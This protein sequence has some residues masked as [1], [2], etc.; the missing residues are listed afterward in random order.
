MLLKN[1]NILRWLLLIITRLYSLY[2]N[3][4]ILEEREKALYRPLFLTMIGILY[5]YKQGRRKAGTWPRGLR[6]LTF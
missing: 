6:K 2:A 1:K 4:V 3:K 5:E